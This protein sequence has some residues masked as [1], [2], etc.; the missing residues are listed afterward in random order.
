M[1][2]EHLGEHGDCVVRRLVLAP[3]EATPWH[4]D[5]CRRFTVVVRGEHLSIE[6]LGS[7]ERI[8]VPVH[9]G[10]TGWDDPE[11]RVHRAVNV[12]TTPYEE[13][14]LFF[15]DAPGRDPQPEHA[16]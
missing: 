15:R 14:V 1:T 10:L 16:G 8:A 13:V 3:G 2:R 4:T 11:P 6:F 5:A 7:D 12:G 9:P